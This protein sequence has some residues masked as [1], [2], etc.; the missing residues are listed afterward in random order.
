MIKCKIGLIAF[1]IKDSKDYF[2]YLGEL[3]DKNIKNDENFLY[4]FYTK[5]IYLCPFK[6]LVKDSKIIPDNLEDLFT[7][8]K[9]YKSTKKIYSKYTIPDGIIK[10]NSPELYDL[11]CM[12]PLYK[13]PL[14]KNIININNSDDIRMFILISYNDPIIRG[15][16]IDNCINSFQNKYACF[17]II[18]GQKN[19]SSILT[20][21]Y[22]ISR[23]IKNKDI[24]V[25]Q[26]NDFPDCI[27]EAITIINMLY[28]C[29]DI[30]FGVSRDDIRNVFKYIKLIHSMNII[31]KK[32]FH[33]ICNN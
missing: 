7:F 28:D 19:N 20:K 23:G 14:I 3:Y 9:R 27:I 31:S 4:E 29:A 12:I 24:I 33:F 13:E 6:I 5:L 25:H 26:Y 18:E 30:F 16:I 1:P 22:L 10:Y 21:R 15:E 32:R 2:L 17:L 11:D 8:Q